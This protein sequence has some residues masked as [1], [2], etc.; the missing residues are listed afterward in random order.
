[1][2]NWVHCPA[3]GHRLFYNKGGHFLIE[4]KCTSCKRILTI[5]EK[6]G[7]RKDETSYSHGANTGFLNRKRTF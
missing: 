4:I 1:M 6:T 3:C 2:S 5:D 7:G